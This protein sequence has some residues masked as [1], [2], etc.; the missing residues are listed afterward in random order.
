M[1]L[2]SVEKWADEAATNRQRYFKGKF[3]VGK[4]AVL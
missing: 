3:V 4:G 2:F 1:K